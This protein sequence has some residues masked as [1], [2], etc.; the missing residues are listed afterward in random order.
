MCRKS[1]GTSIYAINRFTGSSSMAVPC[2][3]R[4]PRLPAATTRGGSYGHRALTNRNVGLLNYWTPAQ[5]P[6]LLIAAPILSI[7]FYGAYRFFASAIISSPA[8][9]TSPYAST[10]TAKPHLPAA[11]QASKCAL[12]PF[13][14]TH[15]ILTLLLTFSAHS[16]IALRLCVTDPVV[17]WTAA[18]L[19][20]T[21]QGIA[22]TGSEGRTVDDEKTIHITTFGKAWVWWSVVYGAISIPLWA[23]HY[24]PA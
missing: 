17:W 13:Y 24:P 7:S 6:N 15:L 11:S 9:I 1:T 16:Q 14:V 20:F 4:L 10:S 18:Q 12:F 5:I 23:G 8:P 19:A 21:G 22:P 3:L 2:A